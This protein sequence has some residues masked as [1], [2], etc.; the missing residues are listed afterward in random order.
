MHELDLKNIENAF[1]CEKGVGISYLHKASVFKKK[2][3]K[4]IFINE[5]FRRYLFQKNNLFSGWE[6]YHLKKH[7]CIVVISQ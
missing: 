2:K 3:R 6:M 7:E 1:L 4:L 5:L